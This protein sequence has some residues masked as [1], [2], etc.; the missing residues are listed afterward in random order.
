MGGVAKFF[1]SAGLV[2]ALG[3]TAA[4]ATAALGCWYRIDE[5]ERGV[6]LR[7]GAVSGVA[8]PGLNF[9]L[10]F[11]D[12]VVI[13]PTDVHVEVFEGMSVFTADRQ[14]AKA[15]ISVSYRV[16]VKDVQEVYRSYTNL[17]GVADK[18]LKRAAPQQV[19]VVFGHFTAQ[20]A[21][22]ERGMLNAEVTDTLRKATAMDPVEITSVQVENIDLSKEYMTAIEKR[23]QA[24]VDV[25]QQKQVAARAV[26]E[27]QITA[28]NAKARADAT[29]AQ[30]KAEADATKL[31]GDAEAG[32]I[33]ARAEAMG[34]NAHIIELITAERW[35]GKLPTTMVPNTSLPMV[36]VPQ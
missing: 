24:E 14:E 6:I 33:R 5:R 26:V 10:P 35:D 32:A 31:K 2:C 4:G 13:I 12:S 28:T 16:P 29:I 22:S 21:V 15:K 23:M 20:T 18:I 27:A 8:Q 3:A 25:E 1:F 11:T 17:D 7:N 34:Q 9:K 36:K 30:A 19:K